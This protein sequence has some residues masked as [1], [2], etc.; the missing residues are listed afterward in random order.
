MSTRI[1]VAAVGRHQVSRR[2]IDAEL[3]QMTARRLTTTSNRSVVGIMT[4]CTRLADTYRAYGAEPNLTE[5]A[6]RHAETP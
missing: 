3:A 1:A 4:E 5:L 2:F 6:L